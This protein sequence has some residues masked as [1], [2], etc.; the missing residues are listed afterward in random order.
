MPSIKG[1]NLAHTRAFIVKRSGPDGLARVMALLPRE[2]AEAIDS[3]VAVGWYPTHLHVELLRAMQEALEAPGAAGEIVQLAAAHDAEY[4]ITRIHRVLFRLAN[5][6]FVLEKAMEIWGRFYD[7][8]KWAIERPTSTSAS[9]SLSGFAIVDPL[10]C[11]YLR[12]YIERMFTLVGARDVHVHH[13]A[14]RS[15]GDAYCRFEGQWR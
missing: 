9:G 15:R 11:A 12:G 14:C 10:Y 1:T 5:P 6:G 7:T 3:V 13:T 4:D 8:G 2:G